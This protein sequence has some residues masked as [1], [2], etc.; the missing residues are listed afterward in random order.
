MFRR[1]KDVL[2]R[3]VEIETEIWDFLDMSSMWQ[4]QEKLAG[5]G[6]AITVAGAVGTRMVG[7]YGWIDGAVGT[8]RVVGHDNLRRLIIPGLIAG[9]K[10]FL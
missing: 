6:M 7:G 3:Q 1:K 2:A 9:G 8:M 10:S 4:K 5:T